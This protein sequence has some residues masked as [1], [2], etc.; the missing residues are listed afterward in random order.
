M[1][2]FIYTT[3]LMSLTGRHLCHLTGRG[4]SA[5]NW[6]TP[7]SYIYVARNQ[8]TRSLINVLVIKIGQTLL[9]YVI[10]RLN[11]HML[12]IYKLDGVS[13]V[14]NRPSIDLLHQFV[15]KKNMTCD[16]WHVSLIKCF[17][18]KLQNLHDSTEKDWLGLLIQRWKQMS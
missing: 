5:T 12:Y 3:T 6:A 10:N 18:N 8:N 15:T 1:L 14:D 4:Q 13:P 11:H 17:I 7:S 2:N 9:K 16:M